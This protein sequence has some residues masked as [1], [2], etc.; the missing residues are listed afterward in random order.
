MELTKEEIDEILYCLGRVADMAYKESEFRTNLIHKLYGILDSK[1]LM[2]I[3]EYLVNKIAILNR[4]S[5][6][7][8][9]DM[10]EW[11]AFISLWL[12]HK[13]I[14]VRPVGSAWYC[15]VSKER[16]EEYIKENQHLYEEYAEWC[17]KQR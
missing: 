7:K 15:E 12:Y 11:M 13:D 8:N 2:N 9:K 6:F 17:D 5:F 16:A 4:H 3:T 14:Y 1:K 10:E